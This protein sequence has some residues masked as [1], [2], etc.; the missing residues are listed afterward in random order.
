MLCVENTS[1]FESSSP[2][3]LEFECSNI[4]GAVFNNNYKITHEKNKHEW[5]HV[6]VKSIGATANPLAAWTSNQG[7]SVRD[8]VRKVGKKNEN[9]ARLT[10]N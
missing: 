9:L 3:V 1:I 8:P 10:K 7:C 6:N 5:K 2:F 4:V